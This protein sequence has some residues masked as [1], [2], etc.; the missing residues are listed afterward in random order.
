MDCSDQ[1]EVWKGPCSHHCPGGDG[2]P[3]GVCLGQVLPGREWC[4]T[5]L[6]GTGWSPWCG[7]P[8]RTSPESPV[9]CLSPLSWET[10]HS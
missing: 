4:L 3:L 9:P 8:R 5:T 2:S 1:E 10:K 7:R 6:R